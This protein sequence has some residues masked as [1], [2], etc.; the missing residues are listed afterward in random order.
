MKLTDGLT[1]PVYQLTLLFKA[2]S[3]LS[4]AICRVIW[5]Q[6]CVTSSKKLFSVLRGGTS[7]IF[8]AKEKQINA[9]NVVWI[10]IRLD[11]WLYDRFSYLEVKTDRKQ[12]NQSFF[13]KSSAT[14]YRWF[15]PLF[16]VGC[17]LRPIKNKLNNFWHIQSN[18]E[19]WPENE[20][21]LSPGFPFIWR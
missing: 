18:G 16:L 7:F 1:A 3:F 17:I 13:F 9:A 11:G 2:V 20:E 5:R 10:I 4:R 6:C 15:L 21:C 19:N 8:Y 14:V 12:F